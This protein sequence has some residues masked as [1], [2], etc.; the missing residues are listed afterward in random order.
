VG[1]VVCVARFDDGEVDRRT[2]TTTKAMNPTLRGGAYF[3]FGG[4]GNGS[5]PPLRKRRQAKSSILPGLGAA[6]GLSREAVH[7]SS[8]HHHHHDH[9]QQQK[10]QDGDVGLV[11]RDSNKRRR[12]RSRRCQR[13]MP[14]SLA[15]DCASGAAVLSRSIGKAPSSPSR[16]AFQTPTPTR[17]WW[18]RR[19]FPQRIDTRAR[20]GPLPRL[21]KCQR[22]H[23]GRA[24]GASGVDRPRGRC[25]GTRHPTVPPAST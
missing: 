19:R 25:G 4:D 9:Q 18:R 16:S 2:V 7:L 23:R 21:G 14:A 17:S 11:T 5:L 3:G 13:A 24:A 10:S 22:R 8:D 20:R 1:G 15:P 12:R 6:S